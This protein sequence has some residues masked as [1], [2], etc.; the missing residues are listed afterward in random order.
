MPKRLT[1]SKSIWVY[2]N[3]DSEGFAS[4]PDLDVRDTLEEAIEEQGI[5]DVTRAGSGEG[6]MDIS[7]R[8][9][10]ADAV[11]KALTAVRGILAAQGVPEEL[12]RFEV[13]DVYEPVCEPTP[14]FQPGDCLIFQLADG[15]YGAALV[16]AYADSEMR[17]QLQGIFRGEYPPA[18]S[19]ETL[20]AFLDYKSKV[21]PDTAVFEKRHWLRATSNWRKGEPYL[22]WL[23][24]YGGIEVNRS[25]KIALRH[26]DPKLCEFHLSWE[27]T[28]EYYLKEK[29]RDTSIN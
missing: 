10:H 26:D 3:L 15:E 5:G 17:Q 21:P 27:D 1:D 18:G 11:D 24:C 20:L 13:Y 9:D 14:D 22:V 23:H 7:F 6:G 12:Y 28:G 19:D 8:V 25:G 16:M 2:I 4:D 29:L